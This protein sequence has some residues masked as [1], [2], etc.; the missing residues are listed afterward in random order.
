M[1]V[2]P[3]VL[4]H[5][6]GIESGTDFLKRIAFIFEEPVRSKFGA[7][8]LDQLDDPGPE[9]NW[10]VAGWLA[11][12]EVSVVAGASRSGK[13][14]LALE[15]GLCVAEARPL[16][17]LKVKHG[18]VV[19]QAG[20]GAIGVKKRLR[21]WR[22]HHGRIWTRETPFVLL[23]RPIDIYHSTEDVDSL[24]AE[25][26]AHAKVFEDPLRLV[27]I[28][29]LATATPGADENSGRDMSTVLGN[30]ARI[31]DKCGCHV[32]LVHHLNAAGGKLRGHTSVYANVGQVILVERDEETGIRTVKLDKQ[33]DDEDGKTMKFELMQITIGVDEDGE[34]I[35]SCVCLPVGEKDAVRREEELKGFRLNKTQ[36][37]FMQAFFDCERRYGTPVPREVSLPVYVRSLAPWEDVK[38]IYGDMS[39]SD[40]LTPDQQTTAEAEIA[41]RRWRE[42]MKKRIQR[43]REDLEALGV[44]GVVRHEGK[45]SVYW[46]GKPL[47][48]F[49]ETQPR[50]KAESEDSE[51][52]ADVDF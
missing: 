17:G 13:S 12:N 32:M 43:M 6:V 27:V 2:Y 1:T 4:E 37:V 41:D 30:V 24:I 42:T 10:L 44:L 52:V 11:A 48:A 20:E 29:T 9:H 38:R 39:P 40:A 50:Q 28:D 16:F 15:T 49:P 45:T 33:K 47:R 36:E 18:A 34:K 19:Y 5:P 22:Q 8:Y 23:Q 51:P 7:L 31:S 46:T 26:L 14:F 25:I 3:A 35:T 21:A